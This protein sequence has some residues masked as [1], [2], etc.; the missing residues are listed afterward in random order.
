MIPTGMDVSDL[1]EGRTDTEQT[2]IRRWTIKE[3]PELDIMIQYRNDMM[4]PNCLAVTYRVNR[5]SEKPEW[6]VFEIRIYG[7]KVLKSGKASTNRA[8]RGKNRY[9]PYGS[10]AVPGWAAKIAKD[11]MPTSEP[12]V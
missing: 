3:L 11:N 8:S 6:Y 2:I 12:E 1:I 7:Q 9:T 4:R 5:G 10:N